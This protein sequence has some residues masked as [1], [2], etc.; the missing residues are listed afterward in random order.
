MEDGVYGTHGTS[1]YEKLGCA[2]KVITDL[3][4]GALPG[5]D[6]CYAATGGVRPPIAPEADPVIRKAIMNELI[7]ELGAGRAKLADPGHTNPD[8]D[9]PLPDDATLQQG[10]AY[11]RGRLVERAVPGL[12]KVECGMDNTSL[13]GVC[14]GKQ[15]GLMQ[16]L[17]LVNGGVDQLVGGVVKQV[18]AGVGTAKDTP[19]DKTLRGGVNGLSDGVDQLHAGGRTLI[20]GLGQLEDGAGQLSDGTGRLSDGLGDLA[21]GTGQLKDGTGRLAQGAADLSTGLDSA[22]DGSGRLS[23]GLDQ[24]AKAAP[25]LPKGAEQLSEQGTKKVIASGKQTAQDYG[26]KYA[27]IEAGAKRA[28]NESMAYGAPENAAGFTAY[29]LELA[30]EDGEGSRNLSRGVAALALFGIGG[31]AAAVRRRFF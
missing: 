2:V 8:I 25:A 4:D 21:T 11:L 26:M 19:E 28:E 6:P 29:Q 22:A 15:P 31:A 14:D 17:S 9:Q 3:R 24:A 5:A 23:D 12:V 30:G 18:Q 27:V 16:G 13:P 1:A 20:D 7:K 10:L